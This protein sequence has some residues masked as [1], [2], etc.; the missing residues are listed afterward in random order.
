MW[1]SCSIPP[2]TWDKCLRPL[3]R[4]V[5]LNGSLHILAHLVPTLLSF[6]ILLSLS[7]SPPLTSPSH[8]SSIFLYAKVCLAHRLVLG[9]QRNE[10]FPKCSMIRNVRSL[11][12][13]RWKQK[14]TMWGALDNNE[15]V[16][17]VRGGKKLTSRW[18]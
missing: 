12:S 18:P 10:S 11:R 5:W 2:D 13:C 15:T 3:C 17:F 14:P 9:T 6:I 8:S 1:P 16:K 7:L 4:I